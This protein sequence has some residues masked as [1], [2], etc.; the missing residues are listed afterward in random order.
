MEINGF[1]DLTKEEFKA[2]FS[3]LNVLRDAEGT[4]P[5]INAISVTPASIQ[6]PPN[7]KNSGEIPIHSR[8]LQ[9]NGLATDNIDWTDYSGA[10]RH[11][12]SCGSCY[13]FTAVQN[14]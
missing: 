7:L 4:T 13:A 11:Q 2:S 5:Q 8:L 6:N 14:L 1:A 3:N 9:S 10:V 12:G